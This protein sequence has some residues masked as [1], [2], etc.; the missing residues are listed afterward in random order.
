MFE[1]INDLIQHLKRNP[2]V[3]ALVRYGG[4]RV[5]DDSPGGDFDLY[6]II[7]KIE[8]PIESIHFHLS[9]IPVDL[10][11]RKL[12]D[13]LLAESV[14]FIDMVLPAGEILFDRNGEVTKLL[15]QLQNR[16]NPR[17]STISNSQIDWERFSQKHVLDKLRFRLHEDI[18]FSTTAK[19]INAEH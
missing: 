16:W 6:V 3:Y 12:D 19:Q 2:N 5:N 13:L 7:D 14:S 10:N 1:T 4:R 9:R 11:I 17:T 8:T 18:V 15:P